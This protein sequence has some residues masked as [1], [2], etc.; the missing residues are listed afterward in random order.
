MDLEWT[1]E[2]L[3]DSRE[4]VEALVET[5][6]PE[7]DR[8]VDEVLDYQERL[9]AAARPLTD[10]DL[11]DELVARTLLLLRAAGTPE[12]RELASVAARYLLH[13]EEDDLGN[14]YGFDDDLEVFNAVARRVA[15]DLVFDYV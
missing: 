8:L 4:V 7:F 11:A 15:P 13:E 9:H 14:P 1:D 2:L 6:L 12:H 5:T 10:L 3:S